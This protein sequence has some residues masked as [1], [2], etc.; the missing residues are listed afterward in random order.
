MAKFLQN[1]LK[2]EQFS[3]IL[4][5]PLVFTLD[6]LIAISPVTAHKN[7]APLRGTFYSVALFK[8]KHF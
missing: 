4:G 5:I 2:E 8:N 7:L 6:I 1:H 3:S